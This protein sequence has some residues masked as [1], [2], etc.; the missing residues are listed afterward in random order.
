MEREKFFYGT[1]AFEKGEL[2]LVNSKELMYCRQSTDWMGKDAMLLIYAP[3]YKAV[4]RYEPKDDQNQAAICMRSVYN[5]DK[6]EHVYDPA[7]YN[8]HLVYVEDP[9]TNGYIKDGWLICIILMV[10]TLIFKPVGIWSLCVLG[11]WLYLRHEEI[12]RIKK[13]N[14]GKMPGHWEKKDD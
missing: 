5:G 3:R 14:G 13:M 7:P 10:V 6:I 1:D 12:E 9:V 8:S 11:I 2:V 4:Y